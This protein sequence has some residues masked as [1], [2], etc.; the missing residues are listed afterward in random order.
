MRTELPPATFA[1]VLP[2]NKD[3]DY[4]LY[5]NQYPFQP[6]SQAFS[7][8]NAW[9]LAESALLSYAEPDFAIGK[10]ND[11]G[12]TV[13]DNDVIQGD[14]TQCYV[15]YTDNVII[16][17]FRGTQVVK[18]GETNGSLKEAL[19]EVIKDVVTDAKVIPVYSKQGGNV[20]KGFM[21]ALDQIWDEQLLPCL[22]NLLS[23]TGK[24]RT[25]W[26]TGHSLGAALATLAAD[27][28]GHV[29]GVYNFGSPRVGD[30]SFADDYFVNTYRFVNNN[31]IV[32][33]VP[34]RPYVHVG[35]LKYIDSDG[36]LIDDITVWQSVSEQFVGRWKHLINALGGLRSGWVFQLPEDGFNDHSPMFYA[37]HIRNLLCNA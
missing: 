24:N 28:F 29:Q 35:Q 11:A 26:M 9:W 3:H 14:G 17:A 13:Y 34:W 12:F 2:P 23:E 37:L 33:R 31:D 25:V 16:V 30:Q 20:H 4:F 22:K 19:N 27:R 36:Q 18:P 5:K 7:L 6:R 10:F 32:P 1:N 8:S 21:D 15:V